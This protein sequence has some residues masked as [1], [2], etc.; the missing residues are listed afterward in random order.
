MPGSVPRLDPG[1]GRAGVPG[2]GAGAG[3]VWP[4]PHLQGI[5]PSPG[6]ICGPGSQS[7][8]RVGGVQ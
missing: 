6:A 8:P 7:R 3:G 2:C 1:A 5:P 4:S